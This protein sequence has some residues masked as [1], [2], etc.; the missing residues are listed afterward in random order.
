MRAIHALVGS[1]LA[2]AKE[3]NA[4]SSSQQAKLPDSPG[5]YN[6]SGKNGHTREAGVILKNDADPLKKALDTIEKPC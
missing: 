4:S 6:R 2:G 5:R 1:R 3:V